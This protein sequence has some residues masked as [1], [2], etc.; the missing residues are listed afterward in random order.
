MCIYCEGYKEENME[1]QSEGTNGDQEQ[2][3]QSS[4]DQSSE[5]ILGALRSSVS[6]FL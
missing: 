6:S 1:D 4:P 5:G 3:S 2:S